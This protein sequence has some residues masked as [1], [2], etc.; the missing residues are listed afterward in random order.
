[1]LHRLGVRRDEVEDWC[2]EPGLPKRERF[3]R[4]V[5]R[6]APT[7]DAWRALAEGTDP[8][9]TDG[10]TLL[11]APTPAAE[12]ATIAVLLREAL[13]T[14]GKT[15]ALVTRDRGLAR[16]VTAELGRWHIAI[17]DSAGRPLPQTPAGAFLCLVAEAADADFAPIALLSLLKHPLATLGE[18]PAT[19][20]AM[21]RALDQALRGPRPDAGL[22]GIAR[23]LREAPPRVQQW[24]AKINDVLAPLAAALAKP[25]V[26]FDA[27][28]KA[29]VDAADALAPDLWNGTDGAAA[30]GFVRELVEAAGDLPVI[31]ARSYAPL[32]HTL[33]RAVPVHPA[34][35]RHPRLAI[36]G[37]L[38]ARLQSYDLVILGGLNEGSWPAGAANDPWF[39]RPMRAALGLEQPERA[40]GQSAHDFA[41]LAA[42]PRVVLTRAQKSEGTPMVASRWIQRLQ[43]LTRGLGLAANLPLDPVYGKIAAK[44]AEA[45]GRVTPERPPYPTPPVAVRPRE[46]SVTDVERWIRDPY[47][48][49]AKKILRLNPL[50]T[51]EAEIGAPERGSA[52]HTV[53]ERFVRRYPEPAPDAAARMIAII[54]EVFDERKLPRAVVALW[55][56]RFVNAAHWF[57]DREAERRVDVAESYLEVRGALEFSV[58]GKPFRLHGIADRID[59]LKSGGAEI[60]DYKTGKPPSND[61]VNTL[62]APQLPLEGAMLQAGGF[63]GVPKLAPAA[64]SYIQISGSA[65]AGA[66]KKIGGDAGDLATAALARL[67]GRVA[68]FDLAASGYESRVAPAYVD[69]EGDYDHLARV[70]EWSLSGWSGE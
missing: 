43:Q 7:T 51:I 30:N 44:L 22:D 69:S 26:A 2:D 50:E 14:P 1:L 48:V 11:E 41:I 16:R 70:R 33:M 15:A 29:H 65:T 39:S 46:L 40:I 4:E 21:A 23:A 27:A 55:R 52:F 8:P 38:E 64:F 62:L 35:G 25:E 59:R 28:L 6:P 9:K 67:K 19:F 53:L 24:Y 13:E 61:Q 49:Y 17:D 47:A 3:L 10:L 34:H 42:A 54:D 32:L 57:V 45:E 36:L 5:L 31:E 58:G 20:R 18:D 66:V 56:P 12:A 68:L 60:I 63:G 37:P